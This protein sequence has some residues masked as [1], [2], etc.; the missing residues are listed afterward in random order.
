M[1]P[2]EQS[3]CS[4]KEL[5]QNKFQT[6]RRESILKYALQ[7]FAEDGQKWS[8]RQGNF[9]Y[10]AQRRTKKSIFHTFPHK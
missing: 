1:S 10:I 7:N 5:V 4:Q 8:Q 6:E 2:D 9:I 3:I